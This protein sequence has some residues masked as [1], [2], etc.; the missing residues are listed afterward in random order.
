MD[1]S[2]LL[3]PPPLLHHHHFFFT[4]GPAAPAVVLAAGDH[5]QQRSQQKF[6]NQLATRVLPKAKRKV[7]VKKNRLLPLTTR[8]T[9]PLTRP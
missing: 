7:V 9:A 1:S 6:K 8:T 2:S 3:A 4:T 5:R